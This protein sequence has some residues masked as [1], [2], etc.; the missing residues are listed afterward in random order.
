[1]SDEDTIEVALF[2]IPNMVAFPGTMVPLHVFEPRYRRLVHDCVET[3]RLLGV[4]H[5]KKTIRK[6]PK[7]QSIEEALNTNQATYQ[8]WEI[9]S[10]GPCQITETLPDGRLIAEIN[11]TTRFR[12]VD[13]VQSIPYRIVSCVPLQDES[14]PDDLTLA[15]KLKRSINDKLIEMIGTENPEV[16]DALNTPGWIDMEPAEYSFKIFQFLRFDA[17]TMQE[18]LE[19][20]CVWRRLGI[21]W[22]ILRRA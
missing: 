14:E 2:P 22:E 12:L 3:G 19:M 15:P 18:I 16:A 10:A 6:P 13:E 21:T 20:P 11:M 7:N 17:D 5:T 4:C 1:M 9:F 8:P